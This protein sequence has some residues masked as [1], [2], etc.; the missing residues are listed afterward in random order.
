MTQSNLTIVIITL[1]TVHTLISCQ[2]IRQKPMVT[3]S[4]NSLACDPFKSYQIN[5]IAAIHSNQ[6]FLVYFDDFLRIESLLVA[7]GDPLEEHFRPLF[8]TNQTKY[9]KFG[10]TFTSVVE[11]QPGSLTYF[12]RQSD[13]DPPIA[14]LDATFNN[15]LLCQFVNETRSNWLSL[16]TIEKFKIKSVQSMSKYEESRTAYVGFLAGRYGGGFEAIPNASV[17]VKLDTRRNVLIHKVL[18]EG[19]QYQP[20]N[21][22]GLLG[23]SRLIVVYGHIWTVIDRIE[24]LIP[25]NPNLRYR[26][27]NELVG[28]P[29]P[30]CFDARL[31]AVTRS[32]SNTILFTNR[33][34]HT[35]KGELGQG[36]QISAITYTTEKFKATASVDAAMTISDPPHQDLVALFESHQ[37]SMYRNHELIESRSISSTFI[38]FPERDQVDAAFGYRG[39]FF[40]FHGLRGLVSVYNRS[41]NDDKFVFRQKT[42][43][44]E[45]RRYFHGLTVKRVN[46]AQSFS[47]KSMVMLFRGDHYY[48]S[49]LST[50]TDE[51]PGQVSAGK[52]SANDL[53]TCR[54]LFYESLGIQQL[55]NIANHEQFKRWSTSFQEFVDIDG[56]PVKTTAT[57]EPSPDDKNGNSRTGLTKRERIIIGVFAGLI[58]LLL[59]IFV[60]AYVYTVRRH[61]QSSLSSADIDPRSHPPGGVGS[62]TTGSGVKTK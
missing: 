58:G 13:D 14:C 38:D 19:R 46:A 54:D 47:S 2:E 52:L 10:H 20:P 39:N 4:T 43:P 24:D 22:I 18:D 59:I 11:L 25:F 8:D 26:S 33:H 44:V 15:H 9:V 56:N 29:A 17:L 21:S 61:S 55:L 40:L 12:E 45:M 49:P 27:S 28:C 50:N 57:S 62:T 16:S 32:G 53:F 60:A 3:S 37:I 34:Y 51:N 7:G 1:I 6:R 48:M 31:D 36:S 42:A 30:M 5:A 23:G 35:V 41:A